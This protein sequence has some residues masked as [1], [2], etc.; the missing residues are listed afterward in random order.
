M[1]FK[2]FK[3]KK[4]TSTNDKA[5][6][7]ITKKRKLSGYVNA[8]V[9]TKGRGTYG[10]KWISKKGNFFGSIFFPLKLDYPTYEEFST[11]NPIIIFNVVKKFCKKKDISLKLPNDILVNKKKICGILQEVI[12][13]NDKRFLIIGIG[14][15][16]ISSPNLNKKYLATNILYETKTKPKIKEIT[17]QITYAYEN[18]FLNLKSY[19][20][21]SFKKKV[22]MLAS[23]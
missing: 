12:T 6:N 14:L 22:K 3:F 17:K 19:D 16:I 18:F 2:I 4:V 15:N 7:L 13:L 1:K 20:F 9:Q 8:S 10:K 21:S 5:I 11:I 23:S